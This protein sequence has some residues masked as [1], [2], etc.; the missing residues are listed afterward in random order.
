VKAIL[1]AEG[2]DAHRAKRRLLQSAAQLWNESGAKLELKPLLCDLL[3]VSK[4]EVAGL[5]KDAAGER[6]SKFPTEHQSN[7]K[8]DVMGSKV[9]LPDVQP[10]HEACQLAGKTSQGFAGENHPPLR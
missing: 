9:E 4:N 6:K 3:D 8:P 2:H 7:A 10:W 5:V 1:C